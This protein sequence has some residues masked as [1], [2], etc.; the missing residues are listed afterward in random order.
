MRL[1]MIGLDKMGGNMTERLRRAGHD[2]VADDRDPAVVAT[3]VGMGA[4][5]ATDLT[6]MVRRLASPRIIWIMV[7]VGRPVDE[8]IDTLLPQLSVGD[9][10]PIVRALAQEQGYAHVGPAGAGHYVKMVHKGIEYATLQGC[11]ESYEI[12]GTNGKFPDLD[13]HQNGHAVA[14]EASAS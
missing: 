8:M 12:P 1:A 4:K 10:L 13:L 7:Q 11:A 14:A 2:V 3:Y 5:G 9:T 6:D